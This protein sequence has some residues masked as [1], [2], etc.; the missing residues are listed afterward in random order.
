MISDTQVLDVTTTENQSITRNE[1]DPDARRGI[2]PP[3]APIMKTVSALSVMSCF[4]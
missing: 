2:E 3:D 4:K 1:Q